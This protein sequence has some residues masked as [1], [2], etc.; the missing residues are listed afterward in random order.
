MKQPFFLIVLASLF[1]SHAVS[2]QADQQN[3]VIILSD[4]EADPDDTQS[5]VRL[6][7]YSNE[8]DI[9]GMIATTSCWH[10][11]SVEP[12][13]IVKVIQAYGKVHA[14]LVQHDPAYPGEEELLKL[15][16][17]GPPVYGM[18][19]VGEGKYSE[20]S[21]WILKELEEEDERPL[22]IS[23]WGGVNT[24][25]QTLHKIQDTKSKKEAKELISKLTGVYHF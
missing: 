1:F 22:W 18:L 2:A 5:F 6:L 24:L 16:K 20:G 9:K 4:I 7:L 13:S 12:Q 14:N 17:E 19:G 10:Q 11:N 21:D 3:R 23:V 15:V 8:I 25:A